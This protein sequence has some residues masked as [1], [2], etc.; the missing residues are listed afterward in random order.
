MTCVKNRGGRQAFDPDLLEYDSDPALALN[1][2]TLLAPEQCATDHGRGQ[3]KQ[4]HN[5][6]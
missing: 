6:H 2:L 1:A 4:I 5:R 3:Q